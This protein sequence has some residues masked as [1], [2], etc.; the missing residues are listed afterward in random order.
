M[1]K[2]SGY[3]ESGESFVRKLLNGE[4]CIEAYNQL[5]VSKLALPTIITWERMLRVGGDLDSPFSLLES[6]RHC[7]RKSRIDASLRSWIME[8]AI[9]QRDLD[10]NWIYLSL[11]DQYEMMDKQLPISPRMLQLLVRDFR[12]NVF[13]KS[14]GKGA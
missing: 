14:L 11:V 5:K 6:Y 13:T 7:G 8:L 1:P 12:K 9:D 2:D 4:I 10:P 3:S